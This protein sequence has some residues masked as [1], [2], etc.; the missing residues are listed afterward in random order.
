MT[1]DWTAVP[2]IRSVWYKYTV[3]H[4]S[5]AKGTFRKFQGK[6]LKASTSTH[7]DAMRKLFK[8]LMEGYV[9]EGLRRM[10]IAGHKSILGA[11]KG[12]EFLVCDRQSPEPVSY[13]G[14]H[15]LPNVSSHRSVPGWF[16]ELLFD[17][18]EK[19]TQVFGSSRLASFEML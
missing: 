7:I 5:F 11:S 1:T 8:T 2:I 18:W 6:A 4:C 15:L 10:P 9:G 16:Q 13:H 3:E 12:S 19:C 14:S 17:F